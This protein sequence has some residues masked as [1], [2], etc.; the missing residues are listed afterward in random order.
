MKKAVYPGSFDPITTGHLEI[1]KRTARLFDEVIVLVMK[2]VN[3]HGMFDYQR[4]VEMIE[5][6]CRGLENV[7]VDLHTGLLTSYMK[8]YDVSTIIKGLRSSIDFEYEKEMALVNEKLSPGIE[9]VFLISNPEY[10][11]ISSSIVRELISYGA[12]LSGFVPS[13]IQ[14]IL[15]EEGLGD[16]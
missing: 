7:T 9:T 11:M 10:E 12:D 5:T 6:A 13:S 14:K 3:K 2:N 4:R 15:R 16:E 8:E 1:I